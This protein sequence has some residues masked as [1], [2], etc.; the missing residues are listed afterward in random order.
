[1]FH[2]DLAGKDGQFAR[3]CC[4]FEVDAIVDRN[5][6]LEMRDVDKGGA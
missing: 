1:M 2:F 3:G 5:A 4:L 6:R